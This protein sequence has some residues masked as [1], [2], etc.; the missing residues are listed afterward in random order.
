MF[1]VIAMLSMFLIVLALTVSWAVY[2]KNNNEK[3]IKKAVNIFSSIIFYGV[4]ILAAAVT[5]VFS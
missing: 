5:L 1:S 3:D 2:T 4:I